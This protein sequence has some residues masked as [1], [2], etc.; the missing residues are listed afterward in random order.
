MYVILLL[1]KARTHWPNHWTSEVFGE[2]RT[3]SGIYLFGVFSCVGSFRSCAD[4]GSDWTC[5]VWGGGLSDVWAIGFSDWLCA[6]CTT[7][8]IGGA[9]A[10]QRGV[11]E[12]WN[13][14]CAEFYYALRSFISCFHVLEYWHET[15]CYYVWSGQINLCLFGNAS[16][17]V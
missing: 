7:I 6:S 8:L 14:V 15:S 2:A 10:N 4:V 5:I 17:H 12:G 13:T 9:L 16:L 3:R 11:W 1:L